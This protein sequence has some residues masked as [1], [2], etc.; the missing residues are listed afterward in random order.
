MLQYSFITVQWLLTFLNIQNGA[1]A[2]TATRRRRGPDVLLTVDA[3]TMICYSLLVI[4]AYELSISNGSEVV[5]FF[6]ISLK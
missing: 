3:A 2:R 6:C 1:S 4:N 5:E